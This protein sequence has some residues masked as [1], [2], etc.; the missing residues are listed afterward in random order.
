MPQEQR[1]DWMGSS[2]VTPIL[3]LLP[4]CKEVYTSFNRGLLEQYQTETT[5]ISA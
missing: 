1:L 4:A 5:A 3:Q 2:E